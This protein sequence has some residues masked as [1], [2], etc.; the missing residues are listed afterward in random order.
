MYLLAT[1]MQI[2]KFANL[3]IFEFNPLLFDLKCVLIISKSISDMLSS[4]R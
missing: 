1:E 4:L 2:R 3:Q